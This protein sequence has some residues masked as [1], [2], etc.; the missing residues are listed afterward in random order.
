MA[1]V[2]VYVVVMTSRGRPP[3]QLH[4]GCTCAAARRRGSARGTQWRARRDSEA[5]RRPASWDYSSWSP[6][7]IRGPL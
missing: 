3:P 7:Q 6:L 5:L 2:Y 4:E 1:Y